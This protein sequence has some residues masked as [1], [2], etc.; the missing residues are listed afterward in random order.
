MQENQSVVLYGDDPPKMW[1][2]ARQHG[3]GGSDA[4]AVLGL[5]PWCSP[6]TLWCRKSG[7]L[8]PVEQTEA[9]A[10]GHRLEDAIAAYYAEKTG[11]EV[12]DEATAETINADREAYP[13]GVLYR[14]CERPWQLASVDRLIWDDNRQRL[15]VLEIKNVGERSRDK[16][17]DGVPDYVRAQNL[18]Y[19][20]VLGL[21]WGA[22]AVLF[23]GNA[24]GFMDVE[25]REGELE[26][27]L[28]AEAAFWASLESGE[29]PDPDPSESTR[30]TLSHLYPDAEPGR[31][32]KLSDDALQWDRDLVEHK[33][34]AKMHGQKAKGLETLIRAEIGSAEEGVLP[35]GV[36]WKTTT[37]APTLVPTHERKGYRKY[38]RSVPKKGR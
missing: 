9:M 25:P 34:L 37:V 23:G 38:T 30:D 7:L 10:W 3:I 12:W 26:A 8:P 35:S 19:Q 5:N 11:F 21:D 28:A 20:S 1:V 2:D 16:W 31:I 18:H 13:D 15:G 6:Y 29:A 33:R 24:P 36:R 22:V 32:V 4:A 27:L 17:A 14:N